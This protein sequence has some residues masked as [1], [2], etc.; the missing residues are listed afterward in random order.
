MSDFWQLLVILAVA[1]LLTEGGQEPSTLSEQLVPI[2][3]DMGLEIQGDPLF[4]AVP[5]AAACFLPVMTPIC[6]LGLAFIYEHTAASFGEMALL[7]L[8]LKVVT[9]IALTLASA[10]FFAFH[11]TS[12]NDTQTTFVPL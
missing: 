6:H 1:S 3:S 7:G 4:F 2:V 5:V 9:T 10:S 12:K 8:F 11:K